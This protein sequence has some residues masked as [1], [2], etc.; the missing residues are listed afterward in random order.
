MRRAARLMT[1]PCSVYSRRRSLPKTPQKARPVATPSVQCRPSPSSSR[2]IVSAAGDGAA[3]VVRVGARRKTEAPESVAP[4]L[5]TG[6]WLR[7]RSGPSRAGRRV[8]PRCQ[9]S[10]SL[11]LGDLAEA[12]RLVIITVTRRF[13]CSH[14]VSERHLASSHRQRNELVEQLL[15][16]IRRDQR[17]PPGRAAPA[18]AR[19][20]AP[21]ARPP[22][23]ARAA[24]RTSLPGRLGEP[25]RPGR[26]SRSARAT[27][28]IGGPPGSAPSVAHPTD[29]RD[30]EVTGADADAGAEAVASRAGHLASPAWMAMPAWTA[31]MTASRISLS[32]RPASTRRRHRRRWP[33][34][35]RHGRRRG[36]PGPRSTRRKPPR[37]PRCPPGWPP[38]RARRGL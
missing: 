17:R 29:E 32:V 14:S 1:S 10:R 16:R 24:A 13:S 4:L 5:S 9:S 18:D 2:R 6:P 19:S 12:V 23:R 35:R 27:S 37:A 36:R 20:P 25:R 30:P 11:R 15:R 34:R 33:A 22:A 26:R 28:P 31:R 7:P 38:S 8:R 3:R 21:R